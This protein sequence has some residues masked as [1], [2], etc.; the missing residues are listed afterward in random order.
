MNDNG[1]LSGRRQFLLTG[2]GVLL[3]GV[4]GC[5]DRFDSVDDEPGADDST[6]STGSSD[7]SAGSA[8]LQANVI[9]RVDDGGETITVEVTVE[10]T[11]DK[12]R[13]ADLVLALSHTGA[14]G[15][16]ERQRPVLLA[17]AL[18]R[19]V[20]ITFRPQFVSDQGF[21]EPDE[22]EF[23]FDASFRNVDVYEAYPGLVPVTTPDPIDDG[24]AW[25]AVGY[26]AG[27]TAYNP[28]TG[29]PRADPTTVWS[30]SAVSFAHRDSGPVVAG[31]TVFAGR[32]VRA[33]SVDDGAEKWVHDEPVRTSTLATDG[34]AVV[35]GTAEDFRALEAETGERRWSVPAG[36]MWSGDPTLADGYAYAVDDELHAIDLTSGEV[37]WTVDT[38]DSLEG[39]PAVGDGVVVSGGDPLQAIETTDGSVRWTFAAEEPVEAAAVAHETVFALTRSQLIALDIEAGRTRWFAP[40]PFH[41]ERLAVGNG[42]VYAQTARDYRIVSIDAETGNVEWVSGDTDGVLGPPSVSAGE[43]LV[44]SER[45]TIYAFDTETGERLWSRAVRSSVPG[46]IAIADETM[47]FNESDGPLHAFG[48]EV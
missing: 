40:G 34:D 22:G 38:D 24:R 45:G 14:E 39:P 7:E 11:G 26:D 12:A 25:P 35:F 23:E 2:T 31:E 21:A 3:G 17:A 42:S 30:E 13:V 46:S 1:K 9:E 10:N 6:D 29:A 5:L 44:N 36:A 32:T 20:V 15:S 8:V 28:G 47:Y 33:L 37:D 41:W 16:I 18:E 27:G 48:S 4:A 19:T 43:V